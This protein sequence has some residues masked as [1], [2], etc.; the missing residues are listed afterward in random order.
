[1]GFGD[2][3][4]SV[5]CAA[6]TLRARFTPLPRVSRRS[7]ARLSER[8]LR[9]ARAIHWRIRTGSMSSAAHHDHSRMIERAGVDM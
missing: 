4:S 8:A 9:H 7:Q 5:N 6:V 1:M 3:R 2:P